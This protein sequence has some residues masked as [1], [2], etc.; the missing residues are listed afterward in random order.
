MHTFYP[1]TFMD[2]LNPFI[3]HGYRYEGNYEGKVRVTFTLIAC[4]VLILV[5]WL[6]YTILL[7]TIH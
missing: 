5:D 6:Y 1:H 4:L 7:Y 3:H 2:S